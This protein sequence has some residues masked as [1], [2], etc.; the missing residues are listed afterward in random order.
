M[1]ALALPCPLHWWINPSCL[2]FR[3][4]RHL[5]VSKRWSLRAPGGPRGDGGLLIWHK[6]RRSYLKRGSK[7]QGT[8]NLTFMNTSLKTFICLEFVSVR[9]SKTFQ[10]NHKKSTLFVQYSY[11][12]LYTLPSR[13][14]LIKKKKLKSQ[15]GWSG[16]IQCLDIAFTF[17]AKYL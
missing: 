3:V 11:Q 15:V 9:R 2:G 17:R 10:D 7:Y 14:L 13:V 1:H 5:L 6:S 16:K 12:I 8:K 4:H